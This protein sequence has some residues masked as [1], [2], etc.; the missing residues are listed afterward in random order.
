MPGVMRLGKD[1][2]LEH[3]ESEIESQVFPQMG[4]AHVAHT[5]MYHTQGVREH[6]GFLERRLE[7]VP[8][9]PK[10]FPR[11]AY[12]ID[13]LIKLHLCPQRIVGIDRQLPSRNYA[14]FHSA[15]W[16]P[17]SFELNAHTVLSMYGCYNSYP[18]EDEATIFWM[19]SISLLVS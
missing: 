11:E 2:W 12:Q 16:I 15:S 10:E 19:L 13:F 7:V 1:L 9:V 17:F 5:Y 8:I 18:D 4:Q 14:A 6:V 3:E